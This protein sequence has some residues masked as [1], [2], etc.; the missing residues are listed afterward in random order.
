MA[1]AIVHY[2]GLSLKEHP[3]Q[4][5]TQSICL[6]VDANCGDEAAK[7]E[8]EGNKTEREGDRIYI[9]GL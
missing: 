7:M 1:Y 6:P 8:K 5:T 3:L 4:S 2:T 9:I